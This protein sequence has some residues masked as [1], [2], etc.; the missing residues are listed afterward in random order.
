MKQKKSGGVLGI[1]R[2]GGEA[3]AVY[4]RPSASGPPSVRSATAPWQEDEAASIAKLVREI[5]PDGKPGNV[6]I[7]FILEDPSQTMEVKTFPA[8]GPTDF[9]RAAD[10][11]F[12]KNRRTFLEN[13]CFGAWPQEHRRGDGMPAEGIEAV[14]FEADGDE[15]ER[16]RVAAR[17]AGIKRAYVVPQA[18]ALESVVGE[19]D[20]DRPGDA[21]LVLREEGGKGT[22]TVFQDGRIL[23][24]RSVDLAPDPFEMPVPG[25]GEGGGG[26]MTAAETTISTNKLLV[27]IRRTEQYLSS[28]FHTSPCSIALLVGHEGLA[29]FLGRETG[30]S[31]RSI[32][33]PLEIPEKGDDSFLLALGAA[34][35][36]QDPDS[37]GVL[38]QA[39]GASTERS[40]STR[41][42]VAATKRAVIF[43]TAIVA[44]TFLGAHFGLRSTERG[45]ARLVE[46]FDQLVRRTSDPAEEHR[47]E[48]WERRA[49]ALNRYRSF[50]YRWSE[51]LRGLALSMPPR[52]SVREMNASAP[53]EERLAGIFADLDGGEE[54][55]WLIEETEE[56]D[57]A[58]LTIRG[59]APGLAE[60][61]LLLHDI[62]GRREFHGARLASA[63]LS[64]AEGAE[65]GELDFS[66][67]CTPTVERS[68]S[69]GEGDR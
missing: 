13:P 69:G 51:A 21:E 41:T 8:L 46:E 23:L 65:Y 18:F 26:T 32:A 49:L 6:P 36:A 48:R 4:V 61:R 2:T 14:L 29:E 1:S 64:E 42:L 43:S 54:M 38:P 25:F 16:H 66:I 33:I 12:K 68:L 40:A 20:P 34:L 55:G 59:N 10:W 60:V 22:M 47:L 63:E 27:E 15:V 7:A 52:V 45:N 3:T 37:A 39:G 57:P 11:H 17:K 28:R 58:L 5:F 56:W 9:R 30:L 31:V 35:R 62:E 24:H 44:L 67:L 19:F 50:Q 53:S